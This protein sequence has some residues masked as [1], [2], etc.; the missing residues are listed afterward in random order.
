[1]RLLVLCFL[2]FV[3]DGMPAH[4]QFAG[5]PQPLIAFAQRSGLEDVRGFVDAVQSLR[6]QNRLP[7]RYVTKDEAKAR[8]WRGGGLCN[9]W[10]GHVIG[11]D[12]FHN[13]GRTLPGGSGRTYREADLDSI[14]RSR[15]A[16]RL[17]YSNDGLIFITIDHYNS[18]TPV[19]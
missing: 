11:G 18:F 6:N 12:E 2:S 4:A 14:C 5:D 15:G 19:P 8:G 3:V 17:I 13:F 1:M 16:K 10:P 9:V 7:S